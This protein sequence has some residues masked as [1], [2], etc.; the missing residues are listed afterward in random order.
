[1]A[2]SVKQLCGDSKVG[3]LHR[4]ARTWRGS[5]GA[6]YG[7]GASWWPSYTF[8]TIQAPYWD[9][10]PCFPQVDHSISSGYAG[11]HDLTHRLSQKHLPPTVLWSQYT[12][13]WVLTFRSSVIEYKIKGD[14]LFHVLDSKMTRNYIYAKFSLPTLPCHKDLPP[15]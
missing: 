1:M 3:C 14:F 5:K 10:S 12:T 7:Q 6:K 2:T 13:V 11:S 15:Q 9:S 8:P 4:R